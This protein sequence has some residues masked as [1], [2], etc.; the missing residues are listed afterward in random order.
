MTRV[1]VLALVLVTMGCSQ[2]AE[3]KAW[4][5]RLTQL[6]ER[7][8]TL[9]DLKEHFEARR[10]ALDATIAEAAAVDLR[11]DLTAQVRA[12]ERP[13][14]KLFQS[15]DE[16]RLSMRAPVEACRDVLHALSPARHLTGDWRLRIEAG[17]CTWEASAAPELVT[18]RER[19]SKVTPWVPPRH[20]LLS[21]NVLP[22]QVEATALE[23]LIAAAEADLGAHAH[24]D[25]VPGRLSRGL[26]IEQE[27]KSKPVP[28][29]LAVL[30]RAVTL[31]TK[32]L[33]E[34]QS[35]R[36]IHPLDPRADERLK[37]L[38]TLREGVPAWTCTVDAG[39]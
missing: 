4:N 39:T 15:G 12:L 17:E 11:L 34:V 25:A 10:P 36:F 30:E 35:A 16:L 38:A 7:L 3:V 18:F 26:S 1:A 8:E 14:L 6:R 24:V 5:A 21:S 31:D 28:C 20:S 29:D 32:S 9:R 19:E 27:L 13:E 2:T 22:L 23:T 37:S 33:L